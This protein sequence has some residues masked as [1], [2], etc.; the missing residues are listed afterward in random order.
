[1]E[2]L[3]IA[4]AFSAGALAT[5]NPCAWAMLP[6]FVSFHLGS[7]EAENEKRSF[8]ARATEGLTLDLL[9]TGGFC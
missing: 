5:F 2:T 9:V 1:M 4:F 3:N 8:T 7:R 6:T